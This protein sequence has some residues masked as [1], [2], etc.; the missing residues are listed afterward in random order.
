MSVLLECSGIYREF[1]FAIL[2]L[3][4]CR[5]LDASLDHKIIFWQLGYPALHFP[6][7]AFT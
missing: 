6:Q 1:Y 4:V 7:S 2:F 5:Y 3:V